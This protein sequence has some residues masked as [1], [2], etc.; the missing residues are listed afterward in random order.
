MNETNAYHDLIQENI[1]RD[2]DILRCARTAKQPKHVPVRRVLIPIL[3]AAVIA[4]GLTMAIPSARAEVLSW[5]RPRSAGEYLAAEPEQRDPVPELE[6]ILTAPEQNHTEIQVLYAAD[7]PYWREIAERF[8]ATLGEAVYDGRTLYLTVSFDGLSGYA[9]ADHLNFDVP[10]GTPL[11]SRLAERIAPDKVAC[12]RD[13]HADLSLYLSGAMEVWHVPDNRLILT[14][15]DGTRFNEEWN[16]LTSV[17][18]PIDDAFYERF[19]SLL[20]KE[21]YARTEEEAAAFCDG[22][23]EH[24]KEH[25][26]R[27]VG[28]AFLPNAAQYKPTADSDQAL[29]D[30]YD[31]NGRLTLHVRY[32]S[33][34]D[35]GDSTVVKLDVDLGTITVDMTAYKSMQSRTV[36]QP[37]NTIALAGEAMFTGY[38][39]DADGVF[40]CTN[41]RAT[42]DGA[43]IRMTTSGS[44]DL[45]GAHN[46]R[47]RVSL[48]DGWS[49]EQKEAFLQSFSFAAEIDGEPYPCWYSWEPNVSSYT[50]TVDLYEIPF[51][52]I[53]AMQA[54]T[55]TPTLSWRKEAQIEKHLPDASVTVLKTVPIEPGETFRETDLAPDLAVGYTEETVFYP[56]WTITLPVH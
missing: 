32:E 21:A 33:S 38:G 5:F 14:L 39:R 54:I 22:L 51:E 40:C 47:V 56:E 29:S 52:R 36:E 31:E 24:V 17:R 41:Y 9:V 28:S 8:S 3:T 25:G 44:V 43:S 48:P 35:H 12:F 53:N 15:E 18:R 30:Y 19:R 6:A 37:K 34:I 55:L 2:E 26:V 11:L 7:E 46:I 20:E 50:L 1:V 10:A 23:W 4:L 13:D 27:A 16:E 45:F 42:L 49:E